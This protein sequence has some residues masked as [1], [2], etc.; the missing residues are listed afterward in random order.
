M[1]P[2]LLACFVLQLFILSKAQYYLTVNPVN[3]V[4]SVGSSIQLN[5]SLN[6]PSAIVSWK[7]LDI[8][9]N[10]QYIAPG[11]NVQTL[12]NISISMGGTKYCE[13][14]CPGSPKNHQKSVQLHVYALPTILRLS[15][16]LNNDVHYLNC[17]MERVYPP[18]DIRCYRGSEMLGEP[19]DFNEVSDEE[20]LYNVTWSWEIPTEDW[21]SEVSYR[22]EAKVLV[23]DQEFTREGTLNTS[24]KETTTTVHDFPTTQITSTQ[25]EKSE[26]PYMTTTTENPQECFTTR[27]QQLTI[28]GEY[29]EN[30]TTNIVNPQHTL[31]TVTPSPIRSMY[32]VE[33]TIPVH[34]SSTS[35]MPSTPEIPHVK[36]SIR[37]SENPQTTQESITSRSQQLTISEHPKNATIYTVMIQS[38][39]PT[40]PN[41][42][43]KSTNLDWLVWTFVPATGLL[44]SFLLSLQIYRKL[45]KKGFFQLNHVEFPTV[46]KESTSQG[47]LQA[48]LC[49]EVSRK[50]EFS[51]C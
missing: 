37:T 33:T 45:S 27:S 20:D 31:P 23:S 13:A 6:C 41:D 14:I 7:G 1:A 46:K 28:P 48:V 4:V 44:G 15:N 40:M 8:Y 42:P 50:K 35:Q 29:K 9:Q 12:K 51:T 36:T 19:V 11:Y 30:A 38:T 43:S 22:C 25:S 26:T 32:L 21:L 18:P 34:V 3:P 39:R 24:T 16:S 47:S 10:D 49:Y 17:S 5:C 2:C